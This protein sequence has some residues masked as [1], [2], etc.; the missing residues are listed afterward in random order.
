MIKAVMIQT[1]DLG[2]AL[3]NML[4][5]RN[6]CKYPGYNLMYECTVVGDSFGFTV[7]RG[8]TFDCKIE[9]IPL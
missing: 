5:V 1:L 3:E 4:M 8:S 2:N 9:E 6:C 7:R